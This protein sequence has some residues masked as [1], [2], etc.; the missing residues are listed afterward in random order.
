M[1]ART[2]TEAERRGTAISSFSNDDSKRRHG[3]LGCAEWY[4]LFGL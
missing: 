4:Y 2:E 3:L 1:A